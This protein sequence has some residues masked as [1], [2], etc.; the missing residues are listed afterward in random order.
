MATEAS[1]RCPACARAPSAGGASTRARRPRSSEGAPPT[2]SVRST[3]WERPP[4]GLGGVH[5]GVEAPL[6][7]PD[8]TLHDDGRRREVGGA[9][10]EDRG[11]SCEVTRSG[12]DGSGRPFRGGRRRDSGARRNPPGPRKSS[13]CHRRDGTGRPPWPIVPR[14]PVPSRRRVPGDADAGADAGAD[15]SR[16]CGRGAPRGGLSAC[17]L[18]SVLTMAQRHSTPPHFAA[19]IERASS[20]G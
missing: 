13:P 20:S 6:Q 16:A 2:S 15:A 18:R 9:F 1:A 10:A 8:A 7:A 5:A 11:G 19:T 12:F 14:G 17:D 4:H 3:T